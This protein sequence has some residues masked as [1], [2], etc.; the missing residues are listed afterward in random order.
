[1]AA[2]RYLRA[3]SVQSA[4]PARVYA[5]T[6]SRSGWPNPGVLYYALVPIIVLAMVGS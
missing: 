1:M 5:L 6:T 4:G 2:R 3:R